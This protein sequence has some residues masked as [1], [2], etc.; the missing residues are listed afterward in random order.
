MQCF[1]ATTFVVGKFE[2]GIANVVKRFQDSLE[3][4]PLE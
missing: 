3:V 2:P 4:E 1:F